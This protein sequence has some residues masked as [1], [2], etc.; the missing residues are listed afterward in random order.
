MKPPN[1]VL[2]IADD[3]TPAYHGCYGGPTPTPNIDQLAREGVLFR[4]AHGAA[5]LCC[6]S[7]YTIFTGQYCGRAS[8]CSD[9]CSTEEPYSL[10][11]N[12][13]LQPD[14]PTLAK[15][16]KDAGYFTGHVGK[17]H[18]NFEILG[19]EWDSSLLGPE[20]D[21]DDPAADSRLRELQASHQGVVK[22][23]AGFEWVGATNW[24]NLM[25]NRPARLRYHNPAWMT[26]T[27]LEFLRAARD[28]ERPF[29]LHLANTVPHGPDPHK[30]FT[31]D[32]RYT[33]SG[34]QENPPHSHPHDA[35]VLE[36]LR[37]AGLQTDGPIAGINAGVV[38]IDDQIGALRRQLEAMGEL[39][40]TIFIYTADHGIH[41]KGT[42]YLP[43]FHLPLVYHWP[44]AIPGGRQI[45]AQVSHVDFYPTLLEAA[46]VEAPSDHQ[47]DGRSYL[48]LLKGETENHREV[49]YQEMGVGRA[50]T[51]GRYRL[52]HFFY[53]ESVIEKMESGA[54]NPSPPSLQAYVEGPFCDY[55][56]INKPHYFDPVQL[57]DREADPCERRN[58][59]QEPSYAEILTDLTRE[60]HAIT[61]SLPGPY[62][63][64]VPRFQETAPYR[65]LVEQRRLTVQQK[66]FYPMGFDQEKIFNLNLPDPLAQ[67]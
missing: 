19:E 20:A 35:T 15:Q 57:Y 47:V 2:V 6:P 38:Q 49:T 51:K 3:V 63:H 14:T 10:S 56:F 58:L 8:S 21:L 28:D 39:D 1:I 36:R 46:G 50:V 24:G 64:D 52:I 5:P 12:A 43:G 48:D 9:G 65:R 55:N 60:L 22:Q 41:G 44:T 53:P 4:Q 23:C 13:D 27:A 25:G 33:F 37:A 18:S 62:R 42:C 16:L 17:W 54:T 29:Y 7:R 59:A 67:A 26:D 11:Q 61:D 30:S 31:A 66:D 32:H 40:N 45:D 34:K